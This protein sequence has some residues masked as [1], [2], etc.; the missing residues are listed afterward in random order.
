VYR[1]GGE[2]FAILLPETPH[3]GALGV[4]ERVRAAVEKHP[5]PTQAGEIPFTI[6]AGVATYPYQ[7]Q[8]TTIQSLNDLINLAD[9]ALY[10]AKQSGRN[11]VASAFEQA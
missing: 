11:R 6:S 5:A 8:E 2:A 3:E 10:R 7:A 1:L 4:A 9:Q